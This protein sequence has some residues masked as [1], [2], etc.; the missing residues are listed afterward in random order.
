[1]FLFGLLLLPL[2]VI[3]F[4]SLGGA[5]VGASLGVSLAVRL[6]GARCCLGSTHSK[7][8]TDLNR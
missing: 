4:Y 2:F 5:G 7:A 8:S 1:M 6:S 3:S